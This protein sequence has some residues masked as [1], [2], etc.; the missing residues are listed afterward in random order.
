MLSGEELKLLGFQFNNRPTPNAQN[1]NLINRAASRTFV[2]RRL[3][4]VNVNKNWLKNIYCSVVRS[5]LEYSSVVHGPMIAQYQKNRLERIQKNC[6]RSIYS[7]SKSYDE[8]LQESGL[9]TLEEKRKE[10]I[11][12]FAEKSL[13]K[14]FSHWFPLNDNRFRQ[15]TSNLYKEKHAR[16]DRLYR[17]PLYEMCRQ[18]N[19]SEKQ[20][21]VVPSNLLDLSSL[22]NQPW[23]C[24]M[25]QLW[26]NWSHIM[27]CWKG[28]K[29][30][31]R[32]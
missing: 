1:G 17:S 16:S 11:K 12:K 8:L 25:E 5:V 4:G 3:A 19:N 2:V 29:K 9:Q 32:C 26:T 28:K 24:L 27:F 30:N 18:L 31:L 6:L 10:A 21:R 23:F 22:F 15:R 7:F 20:S 13:N 14:Q